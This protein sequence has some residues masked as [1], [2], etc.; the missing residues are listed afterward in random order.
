MRFEQLPDPMPGMRAWGAD[1]GRFHFV[2]TYEDGSNLRPE[3]RVEWVGYT[4]SY[5]S[6]E[7][8][9]HQAVR[10]DGRWPKFTEAEDACKAAWRQLR[11]PQ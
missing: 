1:V 8:R 6:Y 4:A 5:K 7:G 10:L 11:R 2:I 3:Y 9:N